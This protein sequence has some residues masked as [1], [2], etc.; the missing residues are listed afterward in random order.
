MGNLS[1]SQTPLLV[2][3][4]YEGKD[5]F[6]GNELVMDTI[7][8]KY[9][10]FNILKVKYD[11]LQVENSVFLSKLGVKLLK[12]KSLEE[13]NLNIELSNTFLYK[14][15]DNLEAKHEA[16]LTLYIEK[17]KGKFTSFLI[18]TGVGALLTALL[19]LLI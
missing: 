11:S 12:I 16:E 19:L 17:A 4:K 14:K 5:A 18:G 6:I 13:R 8:F 9:N 2:K 10:E 3:T 1:Y 15:L 7:M